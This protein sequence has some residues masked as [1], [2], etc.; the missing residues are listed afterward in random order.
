MYV[1]ANQL[2]WRKNGTD[3]K[4]IKVYAKLIKVDFFQ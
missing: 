2:M 4:L 3:A 1:S